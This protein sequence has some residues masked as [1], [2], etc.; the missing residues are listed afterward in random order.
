MQAIIFCGIQASGKSSFYIENF[1][2][3]HVRISLDLL[4]TRYR[5]QLFLRSCLATQQR[6]VV[7]NTNPTVAERSRY[8]DMARSARYEVVGYYFETSVQAAILRNNTRLGRWQV[9]ERGIYGTQKKLQKPSYSEGFDALYTVQ[10][11]PAGDFKVQ[12]CAK[13]A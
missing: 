3:T 7:D 11:L 5:E 1:F 13:N 2:N 6:F 9:P 10:L 8:I 12:A 4:R